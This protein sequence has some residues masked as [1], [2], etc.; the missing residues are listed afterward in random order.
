MIRI[1]MIYDYD[2]E[3]KFQIRKGFELSRIKGEVTNSRTEEDQKRV[4]ITPTTEEITFARD[5]LI[6]E[7]QKLTYPEEYA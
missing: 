4:H 3:R 7:S 6:K 5:Y 1:V 2:E